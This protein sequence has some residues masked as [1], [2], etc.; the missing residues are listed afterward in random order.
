ME[1]D[2]HVIVEALEDAFAMQEFSILFCD[3]VASQTGR[4]LSLE[5][6]TRFCNENNIILVVDGTQSCQLF[7]GKNKKSILNVD[8]F[9]MSTH[10]W[11]SNVKTCGL[12]IY[13]DVE[14]HPIPPAI[15]FGWEPLK[16]RL[17]GN[18]V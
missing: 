10:K 3:Q 17:I 13:K 14:K 18:S 12:V 4:I 7:F 6:V 5:P 15:S 2:P 9:V 8:Y 11:I 1:E 16:V